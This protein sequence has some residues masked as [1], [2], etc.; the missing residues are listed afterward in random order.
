MVHIVKIN[1]FGAQ[2]PKQKKKGGPICIYG[3]SGGSERILQVLGCDDRTGL[4]HDENIVSVVV[5]RLD[6]D[7]S[8]ICIDLVGFTDRERRADRGHFRWR[9]DV[10]VRFK[11]FI[12]FRKCFIRDDVVVVGC[13]SD[14]SP[15]VSTS[16]RVRTKFLI[17]LAYQFFSKSSNNCQTT[18]FSEPRNV[19]GEIAKIIETYERFKTLFDMDNTIPGTILPQNLKTRHHHYQPIAGINSE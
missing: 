14:D 1:P 4:G 9:N 16:I 7:V 13:E 18:S 15:V 11:M 3:Q 5:A 2:T 19:E 17:D 8:N 10:G 12:V 6:A